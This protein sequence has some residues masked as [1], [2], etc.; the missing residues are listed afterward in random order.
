MN[1]QTVSITQINPAAYNPRQDLKP[2]DADYEKLKNSIS[3]FGYVEPLVWN[4]QT[5]N[6]VGGH[7]RLKILVEQ[8]LKEVEVSVVDLDLEKEKALNL[9]LNRIQGDWDNAKLAQLLEEL[10]TIDGFDIGL[11]GFDSDEISKILDRFEQ[12]VEVPV[13]V[14]PNANAITKP[15]DLIELGEHRLLCGDAQ[16]PEDLERL[17]GGNKAAL[18]FTDPP[19][20]VNYSGNSRTVIENPQDQW[21]KIAN[22]NMPQ[23]QYEAWLADVIRNAGQVLAPGA[24]LY[25]WNGSRQFGPMFNILLKEGIHVSCVIIWAKE[26]FTL[27][28]SD[29]HQQTEFCLYGWKENNGSH[30]WYG[31]RKEST[32]WQIKRDSTVNYQHPT[33]KPVVLAHRGIKNS[34]MRGDI[35]LDLFLGSGTTLIASEALH[36]RCYGL[37]IEPHYCDAIVSRYVQVAGKEK[38]KPEVLKKYGL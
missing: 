2:G 15:G 3:V 37:E 34:S 16:K 31:D 5:G 23:D 10:G 30:T 6:L 17:L 13:E 26:S 18:L 27:G 33:Q 9:A 8:G 21:N 19:Y 28:H 38:V 12:P 35:V 25:I 36:R 7:Q 14:D 11:T 24:A 32:L 29:Y 4:Q 20:N 22:D 1:I